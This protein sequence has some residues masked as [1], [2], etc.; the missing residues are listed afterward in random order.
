MPGTLVNLAAGGGERES[1]RFGHPS[2]TL[3]VGAQARLEDG[4]WK[5]TKAVMSRSARVLMEGHI[6]VPAETL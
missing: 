6:R 4:Q 5:V 2:G 1:V 3:R